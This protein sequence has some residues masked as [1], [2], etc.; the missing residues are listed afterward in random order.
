MIKRT[1]RAFTLLELVVAIVVLGILAALAVP[2]FTTVI[3]NSKK[4]T[5]TESALSVSRDAVAIAATGGTAPLSAH[6]SAAIAES[7]GSPVTVVLGSNLGQPGMPANVVKY[8][9]ATSNPPTTVCVT[10]PTTL[11]G[12][13]VY[14]GS[15]C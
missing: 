15:S 13:P 3:N 14:L 1:R 4:S 11:N 6:V 10:M 9:V 12:T 5:A 8:S 2:A 7:I